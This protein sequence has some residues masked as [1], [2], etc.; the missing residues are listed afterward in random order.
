MR[1]I[2]QH[3]WNVSLSE[4]VAIQRRLACHIEWDNRF[5]QIDTVAGVDVCIRNDKLHAAVVVLKFPV[6]QC[7]ET[8]LAEQPATFPYR[9]GLLAFREGPVILKALKKLK[10][11]P[12]ITIFDGHGRAHPHQ[13]GIACHLG[14]LL[15]RPTIGCAKKRLWGQYEEPGKQKGQYSPIT[16]KKTIIGAAL[17]TRTNVKPV[18]VSSGHRVNLAASMQLVLDCC[19]GY[20]LPETIRQAHH[21]SVT[22]FEIS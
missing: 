20:R 6:L 11:L 8:A 22:S 10:R 18:F 21:L 3:P 16:D 4:A 17:R 15:N 9:P 13:I 7:V 12:D 1:P 2:Y 5:S 19:R 14:L